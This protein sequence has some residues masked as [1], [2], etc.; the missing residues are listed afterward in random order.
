LEVDEQRVN[1][2]TFTQGKDIKICFLHTPQVAN[3]AQCG[4]GEAIIII[5]IYLK[6]S[7]REILIG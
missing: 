6:A 5:I 1:K 4:F 2:F 3:D 7:P